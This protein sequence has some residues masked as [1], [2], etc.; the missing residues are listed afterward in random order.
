MKDM[1]LTLSPDRRREPLTAGHIFTEEPNRRWATDLTTVWTELDGT[2]AITPVIDCG[3]RTAL[4]IGVTKP[5]DSAAV[6][7]PLRQALEE[8]FGSPSAVP[9]DLELRTDHGPQ[10]SGDDCH[11]PCTEWNLVH[12]FAPV[13]RPTGN[14]VAE[15]FIR[16][17]KEECIWLKDWK[18][19]A[20]VR[21]AINEWMVTY[22]EQRPH[23]ALNWSTPAERRAAR[24]PRMEMAA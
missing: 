9:D 8:H 16:T 6:L 15:R 10:Y 24:L 1:G 12:T 13:G 2:V 4:A 18:S 11:T 14:S 17:L 20:E 19:P 23:Q 22:N 5:Q 3:C 21:D 7:A